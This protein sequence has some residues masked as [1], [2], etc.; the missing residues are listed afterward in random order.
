MYVA[1][2]KELE[3]RDGQCFLNIGSGTGYLS[4]LA[5]CLIGAHGV[6]HGIEIVPD[7]VD[8]CR[9]ATACWFKDVLVRKE[10]GEANLPNL[11]SEGIDFVVGNCFHINVEDAITQCK[12]DR[13][14]V[15]GGCPSDFLPYFANLLAD[16]GVMIIPVLE[17]G[18]LLK[19]RRY[20]GSVYTTTHLSNVFYAPLQQVPSLADTENMTNT[21][22]GDV[23]ATTV[24]AAVADDDEEESGSIHFD[25]SSISVEGA[26]VGLGAGEEDFNTDAD[27][28]TENILEQGFGSDDGE[29]NEDDDEDDDDEDDDEDDEDESVIQIEVNNEPVSLPVLSW[30]PSLSRHRQFPVTFRRAVFFVLLVHRFPRR[31]P[32]HHM[33]GMD[34]YLWIKIFGYATRDWFVPNRSHMQLLS[35]EVTFERKLRLQ[36]EKALK[37]AKQSVKTVQLERDILRKEVVR[38]KTRVVRVPA[39]LLITSGTAGTAGTEQIDDAE[40]SQ[41]DDLQPTDDDIEETYD[42]MEMGTETD[43][44]D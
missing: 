3:L 37:S 13:I 9:N 41:E 25:D 43:T 10:E 22:E 31:I 39:A 6:S 4:C 15:G 16:H 27:D 42:D 11:S 38:L 36:A 2:L 34:F 33:N 8:H 44:L 5:S 7:L 26:E 20:V 28:Y 19:I 12:Y 17:N 24:A 23:V 30:Y 1:I 40:M 32:R 18:E 29:N 35:S 14:Y 21:L